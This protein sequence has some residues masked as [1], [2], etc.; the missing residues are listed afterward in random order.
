[1]PSEFDEANNIYNSIESTRAGTKI[2]AVLV[3]VSSFKSLKSAY[4]NYFSD[5]GEFVNIVKSYLK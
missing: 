3:N 2:D 1:M 5:I 4:P